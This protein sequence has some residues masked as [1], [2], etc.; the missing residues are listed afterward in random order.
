[1]CLKVRTMKTDD[2]LWKVKMYSPD[3]SHQ[4]FHFLHYVS[5]FHVQKQ[6]HFI[7]SQRIFDRLVNFDKTD[8][9]LLQLHFSMII[10]WQIADT[11]LHWLTNDVSGWGKLS[12]CCCC[13]CYCHG[14]EKRSNWW[15]PI[16]ADASFACCSPQWSYLAHS[17]HPPPQTPG[18]LQC[19]HQPAAGHTRNSGCTRQ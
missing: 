5:M 2:N 12:C 9:Q 7:G 8:S 16:D 3:F 15:P 1:M 18:E 4:N 6:F 19:C 11:V 14:D 10:L 13:C 17:S